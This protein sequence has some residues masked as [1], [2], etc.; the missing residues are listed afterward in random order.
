MPASFDRNAAPNSRDQFLLGIPL[1][2]KS[3][4][5]RD[6][7]PV[8]AGGMAAGVSEFMVKGVVVILL[9][10]EGGGRR[11]ADNIIRG[12][13]ERGESRVVDRDRAWHFQRLQPPFRAAVTC[14][15]SP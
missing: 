4:P 5:L 14:P 3:R 6:T 2:A 15:G 7:L 1:G 13:V 9:A 11:D 12:R 10:M 8:Q